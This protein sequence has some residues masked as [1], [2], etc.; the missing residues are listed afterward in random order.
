MYDIVF[1]GS[2]ENTEYKKLKQKFPTLKKADSFEKARKI[3]FTKFFWVI[4]NNI[5]I[6]DEFNFDYIPDEWSQDYIH[7]FK[8][9][10]Y[11]DGIILAPKKSIVSQKEI[12]Y[13]FFRKKKEVNVLASMPIV[14]RY[15]VVF[16]SYNEPE[17]DQHYKDLQIKVPD[18][19]RVHGVKGI[20]QAHIEA[21]KLCTTDLFYAIDA[22]A[23]IVEDFDF[24]YQVETWNKD[25]VH[26]W[27]SRNPVNGLEYGYGGVKLFPREAVLSMDI[28]KPDMTTSISNKFKVVDSV[29]NITAFNTDPYSTWRSAFRECAKLASKIIDRQNEEETNE[30]LKIWT[31]TGNGKYSEYAIRGANA[32]MEFGLSSSDSLQLINDYDWLYEQ[33]QQDTI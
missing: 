15:D 12:N 2:E 30:R 26:V 27:R 28:T 20:H 25:A 1:L 8:N 21:A 24:N 33:F 32:G 31:T 23:I 6:L 19:K 3:A 9:G 7:I 22:D 11:F 29:S 18:A 13:R 17:A 14:E 16:I 5:T 10:K 4:W